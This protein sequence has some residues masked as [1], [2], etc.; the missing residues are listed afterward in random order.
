[1][2][3]WAF[4]HGATW[5]EAWRCEP[6]EM[7]R[8]ETNNDAKIQADALVKWAHQQEDCPCTCGHSGHH[9]YSFTSSADS[10]VPTKGVDAELYCVFSTKQSRC[11]D[12]IVY[13]R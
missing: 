1:M 3:R 10:D 6:F 7:A 4:R 11:T 2:L 12:I 8:Y 9:D 13:S 5:G